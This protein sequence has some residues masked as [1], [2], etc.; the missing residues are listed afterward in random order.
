MKRIQLITLAILTIV[1]LYGPLG[2]SA[3]TPSN[4]WTFSITPYL[5]APNVDGTLKYSGTGGNPEVQVG[6]NDYLENLSM[7]LMISGEV[8]KDRWALFTDFIY[9]DFSDEGSTVKSVDFGGGAVNAGTN[10]LT[11]SSLTG[12]VWTLGAGYAIMQSRPV[13]FDVFG[14]LRYFGLEATTDWQLALTVTGPSSGKTFARTGGISERADLWDGIVGVKGRFW[15]G[16]SNWSIP[17]YY[18]MGLGSSSLTWQGML[19]IEYTY[20]WFGATLAYRHLSYS[21]G[22]DDLVQNLRFSGPLLGFNFRF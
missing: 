13:E 15:L 12:A 5:W 3:Q 8:R 20:K 4:Q 14:G 19:G 10:V 16:Q 17:Y 9:L 21:M 2:A 1:A 7:A 18:D 22:D 11:R 6:P